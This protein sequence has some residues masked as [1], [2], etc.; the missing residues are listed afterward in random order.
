MPTE[1]EVFEYWQAGSC[2][3]V[4]AKS[5]AG[6][7]LYYDEIEAARYRL[8]PFIHD[9]ADF[10]R[11]EGQR[12]LEIGVGA[13]TDFLNF[14]RAGAILTGIDL[15]PAAIDHAVRRLAL[16]GLHAELAVTSAEALPYPDRSF[17]LVYSW[18]VIHHAEHPHRIVREV[19]RLLAPGGEARVMLYGRHSWAAYKLWARHALLVGRP[20]HTLSTVIARHLESPGT[21]AYTRREIEL[22]FAGAGFEDVRV[23]GFPTPYDRRAAGALAALIRLDW[24]LGVTAS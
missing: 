19:R 15:T 4:H 13:G 21:Q 20:R 10:R 6:T 11:W 3:T 17:D 7:R 1:A 16:E 2:G 5:D 8:E 18:G 14:A 12:V 24:F 23:E 22:L 9:F